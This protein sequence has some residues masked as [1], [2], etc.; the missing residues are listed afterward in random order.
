[1]REKIATVL[2]ACGIVALASAGFTVSTGLGLAVAG[3]GMVAFG[4]AVE[5]G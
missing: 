4:L 5:R 2:E 3:L 1:M